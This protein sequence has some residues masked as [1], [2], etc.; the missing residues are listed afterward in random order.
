MGFSE[1][2]VVNCV[3]QNSSDIILAATQSEREFSLAGEVT[4]KIVLGE[5]IS[6][7]LKV[8]KTSFGEGAVVTSDF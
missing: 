4:E 1:G 8:I 2:A 7:M 6:V 5:S 3:V